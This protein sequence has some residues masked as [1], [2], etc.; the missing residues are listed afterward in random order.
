M[1][2]PRALAGSR[3]PLRRVSQVPRLICPHAP[4][5]TTPE[6]PVI[7]HS[8]CFTTGDRLHHVVQLGRS[9]LL[10]EAES[11]RLRYGSRVRLRQASAR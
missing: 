1:H 9:H 11:V 5:P 3:R 8:H 4:S 7:A 6:S 10:N 2:S